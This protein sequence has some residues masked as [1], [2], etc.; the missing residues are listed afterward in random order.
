MTFPWPGAPVVK[1]T[2]TSLLCPLARMKIVGVT[3]V[4][5][6]TA[7]VRDAVIYQFEFEGQFTFL[8]VKRA[9]PVLLG[10]AVKFGLVRVTV[11]LPPP[12]ANE[13]RGPVGFES[14]PEQAAAERTRSAR[15]VRNC[16]G[17]LLKNVCSGRMGICPC[18][19]GP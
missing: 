13:G 5:A 8:A 19:R 6:V 14:V 1:F 18:G 2:V 3:L 11:Q 16:I 15:P 9:K 4:T 17:P 10:G 7:P 12:L